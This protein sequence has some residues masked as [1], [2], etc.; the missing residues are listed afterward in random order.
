MTTRSKFVLAL[1]ALGFALAAVHS[2]HAQ[3]YPGKPI[4]LIVPFSAG[5]QPDVMARLIAQHLSSSLGPVV[6][7]N[8][9]GA[10]GTLGAKAVV[11]AE[12]DG[13]TLLLGTTGVLG[14]APA[15]YKDAGYDPIK[16]FA[17][18]AMISHA[19]F[20]LVIAPDVP[21][22]SVAEL[23]AYAKAN[24]GKL[25]YGAPTATPPHLACEMFKQVTDIDIVRV[26]YAGNHVAGLLGGQTEIVCEASTILLPHIHAGTLRPLAVLSD[27]RWPELP[28]VPTSGESGLPDLL[29]SVWAGV[30]VP[31]GTPDGIIRRL[32]Q[33]INAG[34]GSVELK[35]SLAKLGAEPRTSSPQEFS[36]LIA[37]EAQKW[38]AMV[39][40]SRI[41]P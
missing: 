16:S 12:P 5:G 10:G 23:V 34:L 26:P 2:A 8:R 40:Q 33:H 14:L 4:K 38:A 41:K 31:V 27:R 36:V 20:A 28:D 9:P 18:V 13:H 19:P 22:R 3:S 6:V 29:V 21:A 1:G 32:N 24:P 35:R 25:N 17:P 7:E 39:R 15:F 30:L 11:S 37:A